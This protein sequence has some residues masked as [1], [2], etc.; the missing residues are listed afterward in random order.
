[1]RE[2]D[3][4]F[5]Y[6]ESRFLR[7]SNNRHNRGGPQ[8][9]QELVDFANSAVEV[10]ERRSGASEKTLRERRFEQLQMNGAYSH[11]GNDLSNLQ[12]VRDSAISL[13]ANVTD[14]YT[15]VSITVVITV[16]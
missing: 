2:E 15:S 10:A 16:S 8:S 1:M 5:L 11:A 7:I 14:Q 9:L 13:L 12:L 6:H 4:F 3:D